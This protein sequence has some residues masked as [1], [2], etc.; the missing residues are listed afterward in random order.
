MLSLAVTA[1]G[2]GAAVAAAVG[3]GVNVA[4]GT[5]VAADIGVG[6]DTG[7]GVA[8]AA[9]PQATSVRVAK[10]ITPTNHRHTR[11]LF[12]EFIKFAPSPN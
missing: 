10:A 7:R 1:V 9:P 12:D 3:T 4:A 6:V 2:A 11:E 8:V 5:T